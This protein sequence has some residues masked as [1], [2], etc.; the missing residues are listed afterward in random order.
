LEYPPTDVDWQAVPPVASEPAW[1]SAVAA[2]GVAY[3]RLA[4]RAAELDAGT[5]L[6]RVAGQEYSIA[7]MLDGVIEHGTYHGGQVAMLQR[8]GER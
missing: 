5:L 6:N 4:S 2:L 8:M 7:T 3:T 1:R